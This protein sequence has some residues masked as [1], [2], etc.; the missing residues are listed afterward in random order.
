MQL[1]VNDSL[2]ISI[3]AADE[4]GN[5]TAA[6]FDAPPAWSSSDDSVASVVA[7]P[8]GLSAQVTSP[9][10]KLAS[11]TIQASGLVGGAPVVGSL[12]IDMIAG[13]VAAIVMAPGAPV[14]VPLPSGSQPAAPAAPVSP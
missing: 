11:A 6:A 3:Q 4:F 5:P 2:P 7:S 9:S 14:A 1:K 8:D 12:Q 13:D 10:G